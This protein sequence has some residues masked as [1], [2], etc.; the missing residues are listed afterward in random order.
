MRTFLKLRKSYK[1]LIHIYNN[2][3]T[4]RKLTYKILR[5]QTCDLKFPI[6]LSKL[7]PFKLRGVVVRRHKRTLNSSVTVGAYVSNVKLN[8]TFPIAYTIVKIN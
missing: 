2:S 1:N 4:K 7:V 6:F 3:F 8:I 5:K